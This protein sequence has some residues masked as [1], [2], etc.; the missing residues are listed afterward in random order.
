MTTNVSGGPIYNPNVRVVAESPHRYAV[1]S[2]Q[3]RWGHF[4][5][6]RDAEAFAEDVRRGQ[7]FFSEVIDR[8]IQNVKTA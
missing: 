3:H 8:L 1:F 6:R 4:R 2:S 5:L 7:A